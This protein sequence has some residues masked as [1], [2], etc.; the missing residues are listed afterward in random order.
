GGE[1]FNK[2][3]TDSATVVM[4]TLVKWVTLKYETEVGN[5]PACLYSM[6][7]EPLSTSGATIFVV[8]IV[9]LSVAL[10]VIGVVA[11]YIRRK[12]KQ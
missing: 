10:I 2:A 5:I 7:I 4:Y 3:S 6:P 1:A 12:T 11:F 8:V 9:I